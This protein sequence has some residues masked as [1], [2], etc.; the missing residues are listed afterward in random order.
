MNN[1][2]ITTY[3]KLDPQVVRTIREAFDGAIVEIERRRGIQAPPLGEDSQAKLAQCLVNLARQ[4]ECNGDRLRMAA[5]SAF[6]G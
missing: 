5:M 2:Q 3:N 1:N 6:P 4:G